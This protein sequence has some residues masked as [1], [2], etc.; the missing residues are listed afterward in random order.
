MPDQGYEIVHFHPE[1]KYEVMDVLKPLWNYPRDISEALFRWKY[2]DNPNAEAPLG[3]VAFYNGQLV[4]FRGYFA[5]RFVI[6][7]RNDKIII[8]H[9]GDTCVNPSHHRKGL[10]VAMGNMAMKFYTSMFPLFLNMTC[11][12][13]SLPGYFK[14]GF[15]PL[16][17]KVY[18]KQRSFNPLEIYRYRMAQRNNF[19]LAASRIKFGQFGDILVSDS[20]LPEQMASI[21]KAQGYLPEKLSLYQDQ[22]FFEWRYRNPVCNYVFYY[23]MDG[24]T[25]LGYVVIAIP[26]NKPG[27]AIVDYGESEDQV[28]QRILK[29]IIKSGN[30]IVLSIYIYGVDDKLK[31]VLSDLGFSI[32]HPLRSL[33]K[34][35][36]SEQSPLPL[37]IR[38]VKEI[39]TEDDFIIE[40]VD[41]HKIDN[42]CLKPICSDAA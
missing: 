18:T 33:M 2:I 6:K 10:S 9:P 3:I 39:F 42:W 21:I 41:L 40:G 35:S 26:S 30:F 27:G 7:G 23:L 13:K 38:P 24:N 32:N 14:M 34:K 4:G 36:P 16:H 37:L 15:Q 28:M 1:H 20:P 11:N 12:N 19:P 8:L 17:E 22:D 25:A 29:F 31:K 5:D